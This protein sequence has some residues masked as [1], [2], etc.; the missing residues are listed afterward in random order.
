MSVTGEISVGNL[1]TVASVLISATAL[2]YGWRKDRQLRRTEYAD[3]IRHGAGVIAAKLE[4]WQSLT[5]HFF[6]A[7]QPLLLDLE[8]ASRQGQDLTLPRHAL[9]RG[10]YE[11]RAAVGER[12]AAEQIEIAYIDLYAYDP[13]VHG[14]FLEAVRHL[15]AIGEASFAQMQALA[16]TPLPPAESA[17]TSPLVASRPDLLRRQAAEIAQAYAQASDP[18]IA[19][20]RAEMLKVIAAGDDQ[21]LARS[22]PLATASAAP[23]RSVVGRDAPP[24][25]S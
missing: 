14:L 4:R 21:I 19:C 13:R 18:V 2:G 8:Q 6:D 17:P 9:V 20:F 3:R 22:L 15:R 25:V 24:P 23:P 1:L 7:V 5:R 11:Q 16:A 12:I 10:L